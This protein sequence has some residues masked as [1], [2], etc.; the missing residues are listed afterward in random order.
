MIFR[1]CKNCFQALFISSSMQALTEPACSNSTPSNQTF[2]SDAFEGLSCLL[3][4]RT[5]QPYL[6]G[7]KMQ[8]KQVLSLDVVKK[9]AS[10]AEAEAK[11]HQ[12]AVTISVVDDGGNLLW[13][14]RQDGAAPISAGGAPAGAGAAAGGRRGAK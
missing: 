9:I 6:N 1:T 13:Q 12:W 10:A 8:S 14:Q 3:A 4:C 2:Y 7:G 5:I 11:A